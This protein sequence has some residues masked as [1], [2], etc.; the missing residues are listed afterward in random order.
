VIV[1]TGAGISVSAGIPDF[2]SPGSGLYESLDLKHFQ[3]PS[4]QAMFDI[5]FFRKDPK[6]FFMLSKELFYNQ[7]HEP[8]VAHYFIKL[9]SR[10]GI[11]HR[12]YTQV[13]CVPTHALP[14]EC[15]YS[16]QNIDSLENKA[17]IPESLL[18]QAHGAFDRATCTNP[19]CKKEYSSEEMKVVGYNVVL[20]QLWNHTKVVNNTLYTV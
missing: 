20:L 18:V 2:R 1:L 10:K 7:S 13:S 3:V 17:G 6:P 9:L 19:D 16:L 14:D 15:V 8:T 5:E 11:L 4:T 12:C